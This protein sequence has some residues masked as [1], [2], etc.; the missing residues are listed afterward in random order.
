MKP[1]DSLPK[2]L[3]Y[4]PGISTGLVDKHAKNIWTLE[5]DQESHHC[6]EKDCG[7]IQLSCFEDL[8]LA[9]CSVKIP[10]KDGYRCCGIRIGVV[11]PNGCAVHRWGDKDKNR[12]FQCARKGLPYT[13]PPLPHMEPGWKMT[14][15]IKNRP[16]TITMDVQNNE[17]FYFGKKANPKRGETVARV[18]AVKVPQKELEKINFQISTAATEEE[19]AVVLAPVQK[20]AE[21]QAITEHEQTD[22]SAF[23]DPR[24]FVSYN[25]HYADKKKVDF[26]VAK[27]ARLA[28]AAEARRSMMTAKTNSKQKGKENINEFK[29]NKKNKAKKSD[30][31]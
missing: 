1:L 30:A 7:D 9:F 18:L 16:L 31:A 14:T 15:N 5:R 23:D 20:A 2:L 29:K 22:D 26:E 17:L 6:P 3:L 21:V 4:G 8:H 12:M 28:K 10:T 19:A 11:S 25:T 24:S 27:V 13:I